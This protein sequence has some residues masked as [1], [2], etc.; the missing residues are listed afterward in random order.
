M[1][2]RN[3]ST[4]SIRSLTP[5]KHL[6]FLYQSADEHR[7]FVTFFLK[8][9][10]VCNEKVI[11]IN[12]G[13]ASGVI[14]NYLRDDGVDVDRYLE[15]GQLR[16]LEADRVYLRK[17]TVDPIKAL[18]FMRFRMEQA[19]D[20]GYSGLRVTSE[21]DWALR[22]LPGSQ[23]LFE[24]ETG[25]TELVRRGKLLTMCQ[26]NR[27][28]C[29]SVLLLYVI[30]THPTVAI[31][32]KVSENPFYLAPPGFLGQDNPERVLRYCLD[33]LLGMPQKGYLQQETLDAVNDA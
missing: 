19:L 21:M 28:L 5:G 16:I 11:Y 1:T 10:L 22:G 17:N 33:S 31:G 8:D 18:T 7:S 30:A 29:S 24:Y 20:E 23:R 26:Y 14:L 12:A 6:S 2:P 9:G 25:V 13:N 4:E 27:D 15:S 32:T 3:N